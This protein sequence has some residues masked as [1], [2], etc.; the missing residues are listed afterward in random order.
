MST[1]APATSATRNGGRL[2]TAARWLVILSMIGSAV[3]F[4]VSLVMVITSDS[5]VAPLELGLSSGAIDFGYA[6][7]ASVAAGVLHIDLEAGWGYRVAWWL[8]TDAIA[9]LGIA[10]LEI[11]RRM[12]A[13]GAEPFT[14][15][16][17]SRLRNLIGLSIA[18]ACT[19]VLRPLL[20]MVIQDR[21]GFEGFEGAWDLTSLF[22]ALLLAGLLQVW[23]H[24][25]TLRADQEFTI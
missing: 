10:F 19:D 7:G 18:F 11:V 16:N 23:R 14:E 21:F 2:L 24:G 6:E 22:A 5:L 25:I 8:V 13:K 3:W 1:S 17:A 15:V 12:L 20:S 9:I 4:A